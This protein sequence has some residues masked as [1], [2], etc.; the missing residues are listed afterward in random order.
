MRR[1]YEAFGG[2]RSEMEQVTSDVRQ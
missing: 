1:G 2:S